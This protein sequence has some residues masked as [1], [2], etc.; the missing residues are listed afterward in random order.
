MTPVF[1]KR[2]QAFTRNTAFFIMLTAALVNFVVNLIFKDI[3]S[4]DDYGRYSLLI[5]FISIVLTFGLGG[6]D[7]Y[8]VRMS[9]VEG[10]Q[11]TFS[12]SAFVVGL[13]S[14]I[15]IVFF[16]AAYFNSST[17]LGASFSL[18]MLIGLLI[19]L[20][21]ALYNYSRLV[22]SYS[23]SQ[24]VKNVWKFSL[25]LS[26]IFIYFG[27]ARYN[28]IYIFLIA[29]MLL[30]S[31]FVVW[32]MSTVT[33]FKLALSEGVNYKIWFQFF[34]SIFIVTALTFSDRLLVEQSLGLHQ[35]GEYFYLQ[36]LFLFPLSQLQNYVGFKEV[37]IFKGNFSKEVFRARLQRVML[38][39]IV[40]CLLSYVFGAGVVSI[41]GS[42]Q[43]ST[44]LVGAVFI[45][46][47]AIRVIYSLLSCVLS[48]K[49][50]AKDVF[51]VNAVTI[52]A[53]C[54]VFVFNYFDMLSSL[55]SVAVFFTSLWLI[56]TVYLYT[57]ISRRYL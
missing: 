16:L 29:F 25:L 24:F 56:R 48:I 54:G 31:A 33:Q 10:V 13:I 5:T 14:G 45:L 38:M 18:S 50:T 12:K 43:E 44:L 11:V 4:S 37:T 17:H 7:M 8:F 22:G 42:L 51:Y 46:L 6:W 40:F 41:K 34:V 39:M 19:I 15:A 36:S 27:I 49:G 47:G 53:I 52:F 28:I 32:R 57:L 20:G 23:T 21:A 35:I 2:A 3:L 26:L 1:F 55:F 30:T 9:K